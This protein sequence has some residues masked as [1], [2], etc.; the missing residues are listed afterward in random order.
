M[1]ACAHCKGVFVYGRSPW[2]MNDNGTDTFWCQ[3]CIEYYSSCA[4]NDERNGPY[5]FTVYQRPQPMRCDA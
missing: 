1:K 3:D 4:W 2:V 5:P